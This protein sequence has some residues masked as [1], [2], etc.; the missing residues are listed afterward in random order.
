MTL[1]TAS[2]YLQRSRMASLQPT[3]SLPVA[4]D[5]EAGTAKN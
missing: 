1:A 5:A 4:N 2:L 3:I